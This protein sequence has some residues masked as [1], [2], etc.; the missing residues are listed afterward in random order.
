M[1]NTEAALADGE[2]GLRYKSF[3]FNQYKHVLDIFNMWLR[4]HTV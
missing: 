4:N 2:F 3:T 1:H